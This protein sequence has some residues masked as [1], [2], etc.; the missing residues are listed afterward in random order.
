MDMPA[1]APARLPYGLAFPLPDLVF[2]R[3]WARKRML[4]MEIIV[5][6]VLDGVEFEELIMLR[7]DNTLKGATPGRGAA[8]TLWRTGTG[9]IAQANGGHPKLFAS[10]R[11]ATAHYSGSLG[12]QPPA[13]RASFWRSLL[14]GF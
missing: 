4:H 3:D 14:N 8:L 2:V 7:P 5:D 1:T 13:A 9:I 12:T 11:A 6:R 10:V